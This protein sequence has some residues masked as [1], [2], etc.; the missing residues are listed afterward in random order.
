MPFKFTPLSIPDVVLIE[1]KVFPDA[2]GFFMESYH[3]GA[4]HEAGITAEFV[5]DNHSLSQKGILRG[6]HYQ[7]NPHAQGKLVRVVS[8]AVMDYAVDIRKGSPTFGQHISARL[9]A[10]HHAMLWVPAG[11]AHG[12][13]TLEDNT[14]FLYKTTDVYTPAL[15]RAISFFDPALGIDLPKGDV[16]M[17][18]KDRHAP[19]LSDAEN[20][21][22]YG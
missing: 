20:N 10:E 14:A 4:F 16:V 9:D 6:L 17:A 12:F 11:F 22:V 1:P 19:G 5:Q 3:R 13:L 21:Y 18:D 15:E 2:R 7:L 8:G